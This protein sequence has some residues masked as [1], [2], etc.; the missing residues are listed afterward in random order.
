MD[1]EALLLRTGAAQTP[2]RDLNETLRNAM[3]THPSEVG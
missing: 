3:I 2:D 1:G